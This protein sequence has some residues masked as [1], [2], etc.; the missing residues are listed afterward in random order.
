MLPGFKEVMASVLEGYRTVLGHL[1]K[2]VQDLD[3]R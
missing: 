1:P 3:R 2:E